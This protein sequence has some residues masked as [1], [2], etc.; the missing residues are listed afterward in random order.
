MAVFKRNNYTEIPEE[1]WYY[2]NFISFK[3]TNDTEIQG[4]KVETVYATFKLNTGSIVTQRMLL[5]GGTKSLVQKLVDATLGD[6]DNVDLAD[7]LGKEVG[8][9]VFH[10]KGKDRV[11]ANVKDIVS[12]DD[13]KAMEEESECYEESEED[14]DICLEDYEEYEID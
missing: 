8:I 10:H 2:A 1:G 5:M 3:E 6:A 11:Y 9:E 12:C 4:Q 14:V 13:L 7:L